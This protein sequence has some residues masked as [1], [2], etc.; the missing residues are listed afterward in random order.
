[1]NEQEVWNDAERRD[2]ERHSQRCLNPVLFDAIAL[3]LA[4]HDP[5]HIATEDN[6]N[7]R[8]EYSLEANTIL[9][10]LTPGMSVSEVQAI[11]QDE[12]ATWFSPEIAARYDFG[13]LASDVHE[14]ISTFHS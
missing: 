11:V 4:H 12:F 6:P 5:V 7:R 9:P 13:P 14:L 1:V 10:R 3:L 2:L 8:V